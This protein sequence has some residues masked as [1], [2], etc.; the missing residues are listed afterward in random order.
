MAVED[1]LQDQI[2]LMARKH[3]DVAQTLQRKSKGSLG[4]LEASLHHLYLREIF[5]DLAV[6]MGREAIDN[7]PNLFLPRKPR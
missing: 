3:N 4:C 1:D 2:F 7:K 5:I 6:Q